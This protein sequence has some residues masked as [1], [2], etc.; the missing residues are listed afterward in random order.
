MSFVQIASK[1]SSALGRKIEHVKVSPEERKQK[2]I[3]IGHPE[4]FGD[5]IVFL[6]TFT[7]DQKEVREGKPRDDVE[8]LTGKKPIT[9]DEWL[10]ENKAVW[11]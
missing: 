7:K 1:F 10:K 3:S 9:F 6:D 4:H 8:K 2:M 5:F 11:Q